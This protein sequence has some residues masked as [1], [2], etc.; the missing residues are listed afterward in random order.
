MQQQALRQQEESLCVQQTLPAQLS[1][2]ADSDPLRKL[3]EKDPQ[4]PAFTGRRDHLLPWLLEC[5]TRKEQRN[6]PDGVAIQYAIMARETSF[7]VCFLGENSATLM[8]ESVSESVRVSVRG[9]DPIAFG[10][11]KEDM[12]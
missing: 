8:H 1:S 10:R 9:R 12:Q 7:W 6:L 5:Q 11:T 4:F 3:R 2:A